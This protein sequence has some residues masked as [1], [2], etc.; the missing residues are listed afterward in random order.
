MVSSLFSIKAAHLKRW[1]QR[2]EAGS[3]GQGADGATGPRYPRKRLRLTRQGIEDQ[4]PESTIEHE[5]E[6][7]HEYAKS[8]EQGA[9]SGASINRSGGREALRHLALTT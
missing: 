9:E 6:H 1:Y 5:Y 8:W 7:E 4:N 2:H 3:K